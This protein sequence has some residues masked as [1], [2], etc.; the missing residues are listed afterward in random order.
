MTTPIEHQWFLAKYVADDLRG[1]TRNVAVIL[2]TASAPRP[3]VKFLDPPPFLRPEHSMEW[4][5]WVTYWTEV[6]EKHGGTKPFYW[7]AK[8]TE[9]SPHFFWELAGSRIVASVDFEAMFELL[10]SPEHR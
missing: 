8:R 2:R 7:I 9:H 3:L 10:V 1:E 6:W 4:R 5:G